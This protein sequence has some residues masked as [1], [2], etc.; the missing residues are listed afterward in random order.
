M[1]RVEKMLNGVMRDD[2]TFQSTLNVEADFVCDRLLLEPAW[3]KPTHP[4]TP[5]RSNCQSIRIEGRRRDF[6][7]SIALQVVWNQLSSPQYDNPP[8][9]MRN[10]TRNN[11][12]RGRDA[13]YSDGVLLAFSQ[14][15]ATHSSHNLCILF[16][17]CHNEHSELPLEPAHWRCG[18][19][20]IWPIGCEVCPSH[21]PLNLSES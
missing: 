1:N 10:F 15:I 11:K 20:I 14:L 5:D 12:A 13:G 7:A 18:R 19:R 4:H 8:V 2:S 9:G 17:P 21:P 16:L 3:K 6:H